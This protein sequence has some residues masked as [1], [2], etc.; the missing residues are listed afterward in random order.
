MIAVLDFVDGLLLCL[1]GLYFFSTFPI[2][3]CFCLKVVREYERAVI[4]RLGRLIG[5]GA[6]GPGIFFVLPCIES[7]AK[8][9]LRTV[10]FNVPPQ[11]VCF[12]INFIN[13]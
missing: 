8:V 13:Y 2:S 11:E 3:V 6:K 10:S 1:P 5:G 7:Y 12:L 9:D 4:F